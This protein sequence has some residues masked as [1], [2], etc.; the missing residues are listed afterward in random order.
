VKALWFG[1]LVAQAACG[2]SPGASLQGLVDAGGDAGLS[3]AGDAGDAGCI[4]PVTC[5][6]G[7][8]FQG[9][10]DGGPPIPV[11]PLICPPHPLPLA[12]LGHS[13]EEELSAEC[14]TFPYRWAIDR[15]MPA[16]LAFNTDGTITGTPTAA[17]TDPFVFIAT[18]TDQTGASG[19]DEFSLQVVD[20][21]GICPAPCPSLPICGSDG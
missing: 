19:S 2:S 4:M 16:G 20:S 14:G 7:P 11:G 15:P 5:D 12:V 17:P 3:D 10:V 8:G 13:Y 1:F 18:V 21:I 9:C 6:A